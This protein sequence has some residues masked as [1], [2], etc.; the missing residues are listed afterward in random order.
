MR[1]EIRGGANRSIFIKK[2]FPEVIIVKPSFARLSVQDWQSWTASPKLPVQDCQSKTASPRLPVQDCQSK[3]A[4]PS[5]VDWPDLL[6]PG[7]SL[8]PATAA[9][10]VYCYCYCY[11]SLG[12]ERGIVSLMV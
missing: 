6:L 9:L 10:P 11:C 12:G 4:W 5:V 2:V 1:V 3:T 7:L 8:T